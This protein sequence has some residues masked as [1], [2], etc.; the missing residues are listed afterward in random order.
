MQGFLFV[1]YSIKVGVIRNEN[2][3]WLSRFLPAGDQREKNEC[4]N[5]E[6]AF[7]F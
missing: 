4:T 2:L 1:C 5:N 7:P 6:S 3:A